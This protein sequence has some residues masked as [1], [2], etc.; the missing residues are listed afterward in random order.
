MEL[1]VGDVGIF[2]VEFVIAQRKNDE[3]K[4]SDSAIHFKISNIFTIIE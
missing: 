2:M 3:K 4:I 1:K